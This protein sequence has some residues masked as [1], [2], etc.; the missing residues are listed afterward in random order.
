MID[1]KPE[2]ELQ[3]YWNPKGGGVEPHDAGMLYLR[4]DVDAVIAALAAERDAMRAE[5][6]RLRGILL[7]AV[8]AWDTHNESGD[9]MQWRWVGD[10]RAALKGGA[11]G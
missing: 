4:D 6:E 9:M 8:D 7:A 2:V 11:N 1:A 3:K 10:A 5:R